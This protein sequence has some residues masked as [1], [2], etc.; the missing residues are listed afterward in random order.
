MRRECASVY[1]P[2]LSLSVPLSIQDPQN[3]PHTLQAV[4]SKHGCRYHKRDPYVPA[5]AVQDFCIRVI[6]LAPDYCHA[7]VTLMNVSGTFT[8]PNTRKSGAVL[9]IED[10]DHYSLQRNG[11]EIQVLWTNPNGSQVS[12]TD[13]TPLTGADTYTIL[14][15]TKDGFISDPS[16]A[17]VITVPTADPAAA[18]TDL[19]ATLNT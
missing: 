12:W 3:M 4:V 18:I 8:Q 15:I 13:T 6:A 10:I 7:G 5:D 11:T 9:P 17:V 1:V 14:T 19:A 16:N 2:A